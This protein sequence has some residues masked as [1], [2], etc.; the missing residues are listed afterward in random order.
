MT[1]TPKLSVNTLVAS[2]VLLSTTI[3]LVPCMK[4]LTLPAYLALPL[5]S[6]EMHGFGQV[7]LPVAWVFLKPSQNDFP[8]DRGSG[9][10]NE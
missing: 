8:L 6:L 10:R 5:V 4:S 2:R 7:H 3:F 9:K 1:K